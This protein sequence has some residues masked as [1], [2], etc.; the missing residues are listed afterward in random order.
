MYDQA[1][2]GFMDYKESCRWQ[3]RPYW[4]NAAALMVVHLTAG[5]LES[6]VNAALHL[7]EYMGQPSRCPVT[8]E[9]IEVLIDER[10]GVLNKWT[11]LGARAAGRS[12]F[13]KGREPT[14]SFARLLS[15]RNDLAEHDKAPILRSSKGWTH[16]RRKYLVEQELT[17]K[18]AAKAIVTVAQMASSLR[19]AFLAGDSNAPLAGP[20]YKVLWEW[21]HVKEKPLLTLAGRQRPVYAWTEA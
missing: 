7:A 6:F 9:D 10:A 20:G 2:A 4:E 18:T 3:R 8:K 15:L 17:H 19:S 12:W 21:A 5:A 1:K 16:K 13:D 14:Q 11:W